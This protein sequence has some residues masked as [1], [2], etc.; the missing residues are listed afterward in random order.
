MKLGRRHGQADITKSVSRNSRSV[1]FYEFCLLILDHPVDGTQPG[2]CFVYH[3]FVGQKIIMPK[4]HSI[5]LLFLHFQ[6]LIDVT[7]RFYFAS[8]MEK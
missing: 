6:L 8:T 3:D 1:S 7:K 4:L 5:C 2:L